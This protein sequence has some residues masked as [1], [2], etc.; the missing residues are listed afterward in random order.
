MRTLLS[1]LA[2]GAMLLS[3]AAYAQGQGGNNPAPVP[4]PPNTDDPVHTVG[5]PELN[6][7]EE[8][9]ALLNLTIQSWGVDLPTH[10]EGPSQAPTL[11]LEGRPCFSC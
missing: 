4:N 7:V 8:T 2:I 10:S 11:T 5:E 1:I 3:G 6:R 9:G